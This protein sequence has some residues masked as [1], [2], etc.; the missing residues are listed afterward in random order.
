MGWRILL[1]GGGVTLAITKSEE[2][3][4]LFRSKNTLREYQF[5]INGTLYGDDDEVSH[6]VENK[7]FDSFGIGNATTAHLTLSV[8]ADEIPRGAVIKRFVR[9]ALGSD[10]SEWLPAGV[11][12]TNRREEDEGLWTI[13]AY[14]AMR[15]TEVVWIPDQSL[16]FPMTMPDA[17]AE[18]CGILGVDLDERTVLNSEYTIDYPA[19]DYT[20]RNILQFIGAAHGGNWVITPEGKLRLVPLIPS[21]DAHEVGMEVVGLTDNGARTAV[22]RVTL[23]LDDESCLTSGD[24]SG[25]E[26][27]ADCPYATQTMVDALALNLAGYEYHAYSATSAQLDPAAEL[28]DPVLIGDFVSVVSSISDDGYGY[29]DISAP[30][31]KEIEEEYPTT[32]PLTQSFTRKIA[33]TNSAIT[34]TASEIRAEVNTLSDKIGKIT[35]SVTNNTDGTSSSFTLMAGETVLSSGSIYFDGYATFTGLANGTTT[36]NGDCIKTGEIWANLIKTG[37]LQSDD[38][39]TFVLDL[40]N[41]TFTMQGTGRFQSPNGRTY[42]TVDGDEMIMY[43]MNDVSGAYVDKIHFGFIEG[44]NPVDVS[45][46]LDYPYILMGKADGNVGLIKKF[47]N[48]FWVGNSVPKNASGNFEG[49]T[50]ASGIFVNTLTGAT[51]VVNGTNMQNVYTGDAVATF[52]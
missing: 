51:Y 31:E 12:F 35:L 43:A 34:K 37:V 45:S 20:I 41:G 42:I 7:L 13:E 44:Y 6:S 48:G 38:G 52:G 27:V 32:G 49:M 40:D 15:K 33:E 9:L 29:P 26:L 1:H 23:W 39:Q 17:V 50:G 25:F 8:L 21:G 3:A 47:Y 16:V 10:S 19:N 36:I 4:T 46:T 2:W 14:D 11:F 18:F 24:D 22:S 30:G 28:G 5:D